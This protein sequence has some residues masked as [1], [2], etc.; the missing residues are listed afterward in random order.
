MKILKR[1][2]KFFGIIAAILAVVWL[3]LLWE[4]GQFGNWNVEFGYYGQFNRV[5]HVLETMPNVEIVDNWQH[6]DITLEDFA[7][8]LLVDGTQTTQVTFSE[9]SP[10]MKMRDKSRIREFIEKQI[11]KDSN[12]TGAHV[13]LEAAPSAP[14]SVR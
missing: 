12:K 9:N 14:S 7:F 2:L 13:P 8:S 4:L 1:F 10:Q 11:K 6:H 3:W 5:R